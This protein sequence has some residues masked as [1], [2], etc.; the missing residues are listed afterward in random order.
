[1]STD[2]A[3]A[4]WV[5]ALGM[6]LVF[7]ALVLVML[8]TMAL[9]RIFRNGPPTKSVGATDRIKSTDDAA[10]AAVIAATLVILESE[11]DAASAPQAPDTVLNLGKPPQGWKAAGR[12]A[13]MR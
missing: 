6:A 4:A 8:A 12:I 3:Q 9:E 1:M 13:G 10:V 11:A 5:S 2:L 7:I